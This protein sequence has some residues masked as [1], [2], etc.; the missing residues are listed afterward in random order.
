MLVEGAR[1]FASVMIWTKNQEHVIHTQL[2]RFTK[3]E[4]YVYAL[5]PKGF[6][7]SAFMDELAK[8][9]SKDCYF[10]VSLTRAN[11]FFKT[12]L[13]GMDKSVLH[14]KMPEKVFKVQR[15]SDLRYKIPDG[16]IL[17]ADFTDPLFPENKV[18]KKVYDISAGG[19]SFLV[20]ESE[21]VAFQPDLILKDFTFTIRMKTIV[22]DAEVRHAETPKD[23][24]M[25]GVVKV[26][27]KFKNLR[28]GD[29]QHIAS[30]VFDESRKYYARFM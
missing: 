18:S 22:V 7:A 28:P 24:R 17:K 19:C 4:K 3:A 11:V 26:G 16:W 10:S 25:D 6:D 15:R 9:D 1:T 12:T 2:T 5:A 30:Y 27:I 8:S 20:P 14:F 23:E 29:A 13:I 21:K